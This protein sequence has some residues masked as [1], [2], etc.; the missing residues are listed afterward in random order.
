MTQSWIKR[1]KTIALIFAGVINA[2]LVYLMFRAYSN[3]G[4]FMETNGDISADVIRIVLLIVALGIF[5]VSLVI[6]FF[7]KKSALV[8]AGLLAVVA[9]IIC[10]FLYSLLKGGSMFDESEGGG[11]FLWLLM[12][13]GPIGMILIAVGVIGELAKRP[14]F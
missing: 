8:R 14:K 2:I 7:W 6:I 12:I 5:N 4:S 11:V 1:P 9:P 3:V 13:T 10:A